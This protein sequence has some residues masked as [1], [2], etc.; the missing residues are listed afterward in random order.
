MVY[1]YS[2]LTA[3]FVVGVASSALALPVQGSRSQEPSNHQTPTVLARRASLDARG[4][5]NPSGS[6][7]QDAKPKSE[8]FTSGSNN[9]N[10]VDL[11]KSPAL[12]KGFNLLKNLRNKQH[13]EPGA[14]FPRSSNNASP[15]D[16]DKRARRNYFDVR[17][18]ISATSG[19]DAPLIISP[20]TP[21]ESVF[22]GTVEVGSPSAS[23]AG[24]MGPFELTGPA[25]SAL[26][27][28]GHHIRSYGED[29]D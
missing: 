18:T 5:D 2:V 28:G 10:E 14:P 7:S 9:V 12:E 15:S 1:T 4:G 26:P 21:A 19:S 22:T 8:L 17:D 23:N 20:K 16:S 6:G 27:H 3:V 24:P 29:L 11:S 13:F 25:E